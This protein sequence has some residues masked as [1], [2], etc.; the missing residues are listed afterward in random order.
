MRLAAVIVAAIL[1]A[2]CPGNQPEDA[3]Q[4]APPKT[5]T[6]TQNP[7]AVPGRTATMNPVVPPQQDLPGSR[8]PAAAT[9]EASVQLTEYEIQMPET[10]GAG[11]QTLRITNAGKMNHN[12]A[13]EGNG[14]AAKLSSDLPRGDTAPLTLNLAPGTY[15][16]YCPVDGHR[17]KGMQRTLTVR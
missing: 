13:I 2:G 14:I 3:S 4:N 15:T 12:F 10:L 7:V 16:V 1:V 6:T 8:V 5:S 17:G 9:A 11:R